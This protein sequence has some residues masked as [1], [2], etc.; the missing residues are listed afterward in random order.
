MTSFVTR[1]ATATFLL[2]ALALPAAGSTDAM[3]RSIENI[4]Q[5]PLDIATAPVVGGM[6]VYNNLRDVDDSTAVKIAYPI[7]GFAWNTIAQVGGGIL[8]GVS[9]IVEF[10]PATVLLFTDAEMD[11]LFDPAEDSDA[12][13][14]WETDFYFLRAGI[15]YTGD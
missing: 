2:A 7:P 5:F 3:K 6:S 4:T 9:G 1:L 13:F 10:F 8:R 12:L 15:N 14:E 11:T